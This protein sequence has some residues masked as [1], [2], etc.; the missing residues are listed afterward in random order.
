MNYKRVSFGMPVVFILSLSLV[1]ALAAIGFANVKLPAV[2]SDNMVLQQRMKVPIWGWAEPGEMVKVKGNWQWFG[3]STKAGDDGKWN[4]KIRTPKAGGP[5]EI[6]IKARN[7]I[8]LKNVLVGEVWVC[9]GQS[10]MWWPVKRSNNSEAEITAAN[11]PNI[12]LFTVK[13]AVA[14]RPQADCN[15]F[16][17]ECSTGTISEFS[18]VAYFFGRKLHEELSVPIGL[19]HTSWGGT[20]AESWTGAQALK[21]LPE[22]K[23]MLEEIE[24]VRVNPQPFEKKYEQQMLSWQKKIDFSVPFTEPEGKG[25][26]ELDFNDADWEQMELP[27]SWDNIGMED[28]D[29]LVWFRKEVQVPQS[30]VGKELI[31]QLGPIDDMDATLVNGVRVGGFE[32]TGHWNT[33]RE[34]RIDSAVI[35]P[36]RNIIAVRVLD[37]GGRGGIYGSAEQMKLRPAQ[38]AN[39][40]AISLAGRWRYKIACD[41]NSMPPK[42]GPPL[43]VNNP[44]APTSL[45]NAM[46]A[47][48]IRYGIRG[49]IWYQGESNVERAYQYRRLFPAMIQ[50]WR[51]DWQQGDFPFYF[52]QIAPFKYVQ[53]MVAAE[54]RQAQLMTMLSAANAGMAVTMDIGDPNDIHPKN[55]QDVSRRLALWAMAKTYGCKGIVYSGPVYKAMK[56][57]GNRIRLFFDYVGS[58][59]VAKGSEL[60]HFEIAGSDKQFVEAK[61]VIDGNTIVVFSDKVTEPV[62]AR[63]AWSNTAIPNLFNKE[64]LP[65]SPFRTDDWP[66]VTVD[67]M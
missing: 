66:G 11:Y 44:H 34:Y 14:D 54:L 46:I 47:P 39:E 32:L 27:Q 17:S 15:G 55:K 2:I 65:A 30:W 63:F 41:L 60:T 29:G 52:V 26:T 8:T 21:A 40:T 62:A 45:Y 1:L 13:R 50:N 56:I 12:R 61:A 23:S 42:P 49:A 10:N 36:G 7:T 35:K 18:A 51:N 67:K 20:P 33:N 22:F 59:L 58:G 24:Q 64:G 31:V 9:S 48:L 3:A 5:F 16:W 38:A 25:C 4:V 28:F 57:E 37:S 6:A 19:I 53:P 43:R